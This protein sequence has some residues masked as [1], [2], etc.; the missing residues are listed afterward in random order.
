METDNPKSQSPEILR[1]RVRILAMAAGCSPLLTLLN[2]M[3]LVYS[4]PIVLGAIV[5]PRFP[6]VGRRLT[7]AGAAILTI[8]IAPEDVILLSEAIHTLPVEHR[9]FTVLLAGLWVLSLLLIVW[10]DAALI[11]EAVRTRRCRVVQQYSPSAGF[12]VTCIAAVLISCG[13]IPGVASGLRV[14]HTYGRLDI[15]LLQLGLASVVI[16]FDAGLVIDL[17]RMG[18]ARS[19]AR[20]NVTRRAR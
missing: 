14:F 3:G 1:A 12:W 17:I 15:L 8:V 10:C 20:A 9:P 6:R 7:W 4:I 11:I 19:A 13:L 16:L 18:R 5:Q 2:P